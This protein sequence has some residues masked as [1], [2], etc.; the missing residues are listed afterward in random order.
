[1]LRDVPTPSPSALAPPMRR[2]TII[3]VSCVVLLVAV[4]LVA[5]RTPWGQT[6]EEAALRGALQVNAAEVTDADRILDSITVGSLVAAVAALAIVG[7]IRGG[8]RLAVPVASIVVVGLLIA[9]VLKRWVLHRPDLVHH[10]STHNTFPSGHTTIAMTVVIATLVVVPWRWR[11]TVMVL[12]MLWGVGIGA[13]TETARW[14]RLSDT[15]AGNL[16]ALAV[17]S[18]VALLLARWGMVIGVDRPP[19]RGRVVFVWVLGVLAVAAALVGVVVLVVFAAQ[20]GGVPPAARDWH[21]YESAQLL[22]AAG[23]VAA[24]LVAWGSWHRLE[25]IRERTSV[26][27]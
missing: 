21:A 7:W 14:H 9:E 19:R 16:I 8:W 15:L 2:W 10:E 3:A 23:S 20:D 1:M 18:V 5:V 6:F 24:A 13:Y 4:Y 26:A 27:P 22:A 25:A 11:G 17:G 12:V